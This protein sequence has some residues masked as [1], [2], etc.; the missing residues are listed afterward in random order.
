MTDWD[1]AFPAPAK[2]NLFLHVVGR[3]PDG[4]HLLQTLF[5]LVD[6]GDT[7]R[8]ALRTDGR[9]L[10]FRPLAG[11]PEE[12]DLCLRAARLLQRRLQQ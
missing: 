7:L 10:R 5:R 2:I 8:F 9:I 1:S 11:V 3:R 12:R 4:Y 6:H